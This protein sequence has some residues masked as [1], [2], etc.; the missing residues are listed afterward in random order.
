VVQGIFIYCISVSGALHVCFCI[1]YALSTAAVSSG[2]HISG[3]AV[4]GASVSD[5]VVSDEVLHLLYLL[6]M[7]L[8]KLYRAR[9]EQVCIRGRSVF[10][11]VGAG[12]ASSVTISTP[13]CN[14]C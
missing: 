6:L 4:R 8:V 12:S 3:A 10:G 14:G 2:C 11:A 7:Y 5:A 13:A 9:L 1:W